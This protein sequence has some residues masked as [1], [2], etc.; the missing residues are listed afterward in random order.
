MPIT[1]KKIKAYLPLRFLA[2]ALAGAAASRSALATAAAASRSALAAAAEKLRGHTSL[3]VIPGAEITHVPPALIKEMVDK[4]RALGAAIVL[5]H[6]ETPVEPVIEGTNRAAI[7]AGADILSHPG[8]IKAED[9]ELAKKNGVA[10]E[11]TARK[12]HSLTNGHVAALA[13]KYGANIVINTDAHEPG[14]L[15]SS[16]MAEIVLKGAGLDRERIEAALETSKSIV[17]K[18][19]N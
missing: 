6:G 10:L 18:V 9:V 15:I 3:V 14:D 8:L 11:V 19:R 16:Q 13:T 2:V 4:A 1:S 12:G 17:D 7:E 5:V